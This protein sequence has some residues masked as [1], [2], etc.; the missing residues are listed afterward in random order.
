MNHVFFQLCHV[1]LEPSLFQTASS[2]V[3]CGLDSIIV[4]GSAE[5]SQCLIVS[6]SGAT[7][8]TFLPGF[9]AAIQV[10]FLNFFK[11]KNL[12]L[13]SLLSSLLNDERNFH[14]VQKPYP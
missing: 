11:Q 1:K 6:T 10:F 5:S 8:E 14:R 2:V 4:F 9:I 13:N 12:N 7:E 3:W